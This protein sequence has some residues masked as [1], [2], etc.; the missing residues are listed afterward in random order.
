MIALER[1]KDYIIV[2]DSKSIKATLNERLS[3]KLSIVFFFV[4]LCF[5]FAFFSVI[6]FIAKK[7]ILAFVALICVLLFCV[8][9]KRSFAF[10]KKRQEMFCFEINS[11]GLCLRDI[12][13]SYSLPWNNVNSFGIVNHTLSAGVLTTHYQSCLY[14]SVEKHDESFLRKKCFRRNNNTGSNEQM[15]IFPFGIDNVEEEYKAFRE[16]IYRYCDKEKEQNF[17][18]IVV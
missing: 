18:Q 15:I 6:F 16:Y 1:L 17:I 7:Y 4:L 5:P 9:A 2:R 3:D 12:D 13:G 11:E 14:F 10:S 8:S